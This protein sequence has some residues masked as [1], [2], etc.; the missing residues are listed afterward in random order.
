MGWREHR[1]RGEILVRLL[2][3]FNTQVGVSFSVLSELKS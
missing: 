2:E 1:G 3:V